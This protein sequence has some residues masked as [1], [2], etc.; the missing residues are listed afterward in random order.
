MASSENWA[1]INGKNDFDNFEVKEV[2]GALLMSLLEESQGEEC[3][4]ERLKSVIQ[5]LEAEIDSD[6][7][8]GHDSLVEPEW[9]SHMEGCQRCRAGQVDSHDCLISHDLD[10]NWMGMDMNMNMNMDMV[11]ASMANDDM[12]NWYMDPCGDEMHEI[13]EF[14]V[15]SIQSFFLYNMASLV[16]EN[17]A[18][19][20]N[21]EVSE[22]DGDLLMSL[23]EESLLDDGNEE[24]LR[25]VIQSLEAEIDPIMMEDHN[26]PM[27]PKLDGF[28][29]DC[30]LSDVRQVDSQDCL[31]SHDLDINWIDM[32]VVAL[33]STYD[34]MTNNWCMDPCGG[35]MDGIIEFGEVGD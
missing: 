22:I 18:C 16:F 6:M 14:G 29:E 35:E 12:T 15:L 2:D 20:N 33:S 27:E 4:D 25:R 10:F 11:M 24:R 1:C 19:I 5:S 7:M 23:L 28:M 21:D 26:S 8:D 30:Q 31:T 34:D 17:W 9:C 32:D 3:D 13:I